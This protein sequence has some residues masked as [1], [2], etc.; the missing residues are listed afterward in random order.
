MVCSQLPILTYKTVC[1]DN[2]LTSSTIT[3]PQLGALAGQSWT[4]SA[5]RTRCCLLV[6]GPQRTKEEHQRSHFKTVTQASMCRGIKAITD[7]KGNSPKL[8][9]M[10]HYFFACFDHQRGQR[11]NNRMYIQAS[12]L[13]PL[14]CATFLV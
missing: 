1:T 4:L 12:T 3:V 9:D 2:V 5:Q 10:P 6:G 7:Y 11:H 8:S 14:F 13:G